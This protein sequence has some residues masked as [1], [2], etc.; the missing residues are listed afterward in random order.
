MRKLSPSPFIHWTITGTTLEA[1][2]VGEAPD[3][4]LAL[5]GVESKGR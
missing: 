1:E 5:R 2:P 4:L 3:P